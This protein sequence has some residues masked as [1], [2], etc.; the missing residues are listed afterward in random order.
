VTIQIE[1][2]KWYARADG[3]VHGP[4]HRKYDDRN[5][6]PFEIDGASYARNGRFYHHQ[7]TAHL[8]LVREVPA[9]AAAEPEWA[10]KVEAEAAEERPLVLEEGKRYR[11]RSGDVF[12]P[13][14]Q[15]PNLPDIMWVSGDHNTA[16]YKDGRISPPSNPDRPEDLVAEA[17]DPLLRAMIDDGIV[18]EPVADIKTHIADEA[19]RIV[20]GARR[21]AYGT[22]EANFERIARF[23]QAYFEST[24]RGSILITA[25]DVSPMMRLMKEARLCESPQH[26][27]SFIDLIG[28]TLTGAEVNGVKPPSA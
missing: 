2:G 7:E 3:S 19:K 10:A 12:G 17:K 16:R 1:E 23:W 26:L 5:M 24:G 8:D 27:D 13:Y 4:A 14:S 9:P 21:S 22:P 15:H 6:Y 25:A 18:T 11:T 20:S 28:Y